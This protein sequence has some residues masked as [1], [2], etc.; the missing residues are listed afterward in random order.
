MISKFLFILKIK[1]E[2]K[3]EDGF[4]ELALLYN[5]ARSSTV[6]AVENSTLWFIDRLKFRRAV[7]D[8]V[9]KNYEEN[10]KFMEISDFYRNSSN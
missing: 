3:R 5:S 9:L 8:I 7:E 1:R 4:G 2:L 10:R 6:K